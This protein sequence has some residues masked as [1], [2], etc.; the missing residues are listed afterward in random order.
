MAKRKAKTTTDKFAQTLDAQLRRERFVVA[1]VKYL[2]AGKA[3]RESG[4]HGT[5]ESMRE[6][7]HRLLK[8]PAI[9]AAVLERQA[10]L[11]RETNLDT[12]EIIGHLQAMRNF[13][14]RLLYNDDGSLKLPGELPPLAARIVQGVVRKHRTIPMG[15]DRDPC[16]EVHEEVKLPGRMEA[17]VK[18]GQHIGLF[19]DKLTV[20]LNPH[21]FEQAVN[22]GHERA[23]KRS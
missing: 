23:R 10:D 11:I 13:D 3:A 12:T 5:A 18:L 19:G 15:G 20:N 1:Y 14:I 7:G 16:V 2:D 4:H 21:E 9:R 6:I 17:A 22:E 8:I